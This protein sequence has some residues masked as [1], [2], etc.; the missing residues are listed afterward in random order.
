MILYPMPG[1]SRVAIFG[2]RV[3][4]VWTLV[5]SSWICGGWVGQVECSSTV[6]IT[7]FRKSGLSAEMGYKV[8]PRLRESRIVAPPGRKFT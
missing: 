1:N 4:L 6:A 7:E 8:G 2:C 5:W 3:H